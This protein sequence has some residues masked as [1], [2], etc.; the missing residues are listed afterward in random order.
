MLRPL[1]EES[2]AI[3]CFGGWSHDGERIAWTANRR[4]PRHFDVSVQDVTTGGITCVWQTEGMNDVAGW[5]PDDGCLIVV[6]SHSSF[7]QDLYL[8]DLLSGTVR[9]LTPDRG[10]TSYGNVRWAVDGRGLN[11][12]PD[13]GREFSDLAY[14]DLAPTEE[15]RHAAMSLLLAPGWD[16]EALALSSDGRHLAYLTNT[17]GTSELGLLDEATHRALLGPPI[18]RGVIGPPRLHR[19]APRLDFAPGGRKL[20]FTLSSPMHNADVWVMDLDAQDASPVTH[21]SRAG[22]P[23]GSFVEPELVHFPS[24][25][26]LEIPGL[27]YLP[28]GAQRDGHLPA[29]V[30]VH[31]GPESQRR[32]EF[33]LLYQYFVNRGYGVFAP[34]VRGSS[35]Y[36]LTYVHLDD[37]EKRMDSV[38]DLAEGARWLADAGVADPRRVAVMGGSYGGFMVLAAL[39]SYPDLWA[40]GVDIVGIANFVTFLENTAPWRRHLREAEYGSLTTDRELLRDISP[41][42]RVERIMA[43]LLVIHGAND[44]RVPIGEAEQ[45]VQALG[46]R[47]VPVEYLRYGDEGHGLVRLANRLDA[48]PKVADFLDRHLGA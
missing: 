1:T 41:I 19:R 8:T 24:F 5:L 15:G 2:E 9:H 30:E 6:R 27:L 33:D 38:A 48:Y 45:I 10:Q 26:G 35:G 23:R 44:P 34:N 36:G 3:H 17:D 22:I 14:M 28:A 29:I 46:T 25:D 11:L 16:V 40:A 18:P 4:D 31:G 7:D 39:T 37:V 43:P 13:R 42:H 20:A 12:V 32:P 47:G 21:S